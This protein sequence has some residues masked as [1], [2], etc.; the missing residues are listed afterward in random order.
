MRVPAAATSARRRIARGPNNGRRRDNEQNRQA[1][2][3]GRYSKH[4]A[5]LESFRD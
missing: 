4:L 1:Q 5:R 3:A 2:H